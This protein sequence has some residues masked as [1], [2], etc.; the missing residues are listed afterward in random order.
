LY[1]IAG[2]FSLLKPPTPSLHERNLLDKINFT[3]L[4]LPVET[5]TPKII[6]KETMIPNII[7]DNNDINDKND[8]TT[9]VKINN[10][11]NL[12]I[13]PDARLFA[14]LII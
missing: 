5:N 9:S 2:C 14:M 11:P 1:H 6:V 4:K 12:P 7:N 13:L 3:I 8:N 10:Y